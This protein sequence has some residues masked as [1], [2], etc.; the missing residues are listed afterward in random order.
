MILE[1]GQKQGVE[2]VVQRQILRRDFQIRFR[3][4]FRRC[5]EGTNG[6]E[7]VKKILTGH[8]RTYIM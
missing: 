4:L 6:V 3:A 8:V 5:T 1:F 7:S 2:A